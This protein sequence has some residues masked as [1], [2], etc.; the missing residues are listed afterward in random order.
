MVGSPA[1]NGAVGIRGRGPVVGSVVAS[2]VTGAIPTASRG[3]GA[4]VA[5]SEGRG[6]DD[7][8]LV[9]VAVAPQRQ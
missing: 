6:V 8:P 1:P 5:R 4:G 2:A 9:A 3:W 7:G